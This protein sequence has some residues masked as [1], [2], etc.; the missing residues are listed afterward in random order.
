MQ[1]RTTS[2][3]FSLFGLAYTLN[4]NIDKDDILRVVML[5]RLSRTFVSE[6]PCH[7][8]H[9]HPALYT[10]N[11]AQHYNTNLGWVPVLV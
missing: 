1:I 10:G 7:K 5:V 4:E 3:F 11:P 2:N 8:G 6:S 9:E